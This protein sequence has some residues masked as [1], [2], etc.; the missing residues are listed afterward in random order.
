MKKK[1]KVRLKQNHV[2]SGHETDRD[3]LEKGREGS[4]DL[5]CDQLVYGQSLVNLL[6]LNKMETEMENGLR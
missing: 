5:K 1:S 2:Q 4:I 3:W 6:H